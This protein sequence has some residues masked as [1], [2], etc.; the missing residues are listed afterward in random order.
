MSYEI[1][2]LE[3]K[4]V[5]GK[6]IVTSNADPKMVEKIGGLWGEMYQ[7]ENGYFKDIKNLKGE[8][9]MGV[10]SDYQSDGSYTVTVGGEVSVADNTDL[11]VKKLVKG[12]YAK[13]SFHGDMVKTVAEGWGEVWN[14]K[15][16]RTFT[17]D[18]EC[19][20]C[21][22]CPKMQSNNF[23]ECDNC[24]DCDIDIFVAIK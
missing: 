13:F 9:A 3:E 10:Y 14:T 5:V 7:P 12:K 8:N 2:E 20:S 19:Y 21:D 4:I 6:S 24:Q 18:F 16:D 11:T 15:L 23:S 22:N 1:V 17:G